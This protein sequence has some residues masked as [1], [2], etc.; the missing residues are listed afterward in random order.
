MQCIMQNTLSLL[1][2][3]APLGLFLVSIAAQ[4]HR[5]SPSG[6][7][8]VAEL[9]A[10]LGFG[11]AM[12]A[13]ASVLT[14]GSTTSP[15]LGVDGM[16]LSLRLDLLSTTMYAVV[17][18]VGLLVVRYARSYMAGDP[19]HGDFVGRLCLAL[20][21]VSL[22]TLSGNIVQLLVAWMAASFALHQLLVFFK[23]RPR[24]VIAGRKKMI[25]ARLGDAFLIAAVVLLAK[26]FGTTDIATIASQAAGADALPRGA[27]IAAWLIVGAALLKSAQLPFHSWLPEVMET[28]TPVSALLHAGLINSGGFLVIRF[29]DLVVLEPGAMT[30]LVAVGSAT[31]VFG[32]VVMLTQTTIKSSLAYSTMAQMGFMMLEC[33]L[34]AFPIAILHLVGH[35]LYKAHAFL[36]AGDSVISGPASAQTT[37]MGRLPAAVAV[38]AGALAVVGVGSFVGAN[39]DPNWTATAALAGV[40]GLGVVLWVGKQLE[41]WRQPATLAAALATV[42]AAPALFF[43]LKGGLVWLY[44]PQLAV[45]PPPTIAAQAIVALALVA[46]AAIV[47]VQLVG[48]PDGRLA[49]RLYVLAHNAAYLG[50]LADRWTG[51]L[52]VRSTRESGELGSAE[53]VARTYSP[54]PSGVVEAASPPDHDEIASAVERAARAV[55]PLWPLSDFVAVNPFLGLLDRPFE[56]AG[57]WLERSAGARTTMTRGFYADAIDAGEIT[58]EDLK[59]AIAAS[60]GEIDLETVERGARQQDRAIFAAP[61]VADLAQG[62]TGIDVPRIVVEHLGDWASSHFD[63]G[64]G[65]WSSPFR[66]LPTYGAWRAW[67]TLDRSPEVHGIASMRA[68][69][70]Q[71][72]DSADETI[73]LCVE[74]LGLEAK[75]LDLY[76]Q[77]LLMRFSGWAGHLRWAGWNSELAGKPPQ[78]LDDLLAIALAWEWVILEGDPRVANAWCVARTELV[79]ASL[80][81]AE[82]EIDLALHRA[83]EIATQRRLSERLSAAAPVSQAEAAAQVVFCID[84]RS[85]R[86]RRSLEACSPGIQTLGFAGFFGMA[87]EWIPLGEER[88]V[89]SCPVLLEPGHAVRETSPDAAERIARNRFRRGMAKAFA[90]FKGAAVSSFGFVEALGLAYAWKLLRDGFG[91]GSP[92]RSEAGEAEPSF[93]VESLGGRVVGIDLEDRVALAEGALR[94][95]SLTEGFAPLV[96]LAAHRSTTANNPYAAGLDCGACGGRSGEPNARVAAATLNDPEVR[97]ELVARGIQ[98]PE[99]TRFVAAVHDTTTDSLTLSDRGAIPELHAERVE[100]LEAAFARA[101]GLAR[102]ERAPMLG[103]EG[104]ADQEIFERAKDWSQVRPEWG[105]AGCT[106]F[107]VAPRYLSAGTELGSG[108]F[109][110][111]YVWSADEDFSVLELIMTAPMVVASWINLQYFASTV[112]NRAFGAGDKVLHNVAAGLGVVE[113][114][115]GDLRVGLPIQSVHDGKEFCHR[116]SR[117]TATI[118]APIEAINSVIAKHELLRDLLDNDWIHL[119]ALSDAGEITHRYAGNLEWTTLPPAAAEAAA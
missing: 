59:A 61:T 3:L 31:A 15:L 17:S 25:A 40:F 20:G 39:A 24:A 21:A 66:D 8:R 60:S 50:A 73:S 103:I 91:L 57:A 65:R 83:Y 28:P 97:R 13:G 27:D 5:F 41:N 2:V 72:P 74:L 77:R 90:A 45:A 78:G 22:L 99:E 38:C 80:P 102:M 113:G 76:F 64:Q 98:V 107:I 26:G 93:A 16:G 70:A 4:S 36:S 109:L 58:R 19:R 81:D 88:G 106:S 71:L 68:R 85:E 89:A 9:A 56:D 7:Q 23:H 42:V 6:I 14:A 100:A 43:G 101:G 112:D 84:V 111:E 75:E 12:L 29:A 33:G 118:A 51:S 92:L 10:G 119:V 115:G 105:L 95:M 46:M 49:R 67:A 62:I 30:A 86:V 110:H 47:W 52:R 94:G 87:V 35:S 53:P 11:L 104:G 114:N 108:S 117:L 82:R 116:P 54:G 69:V 96:V 34:G 55:P 32:S 44:G 37:P 63:R 79:T 48:F 18:F 1:P